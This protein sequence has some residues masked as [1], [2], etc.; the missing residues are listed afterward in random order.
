[1]EEQ[2]AS[3]RVGCDGIPAPDGDRRTPQWS[4]LTR[5]SHIFSSAVRESLEVGLLRDV[6]GDGL[7]LAQLHLLRFIVLTDDPPVGRVAEFLGVSAPA[8][9]KN[10]DKLES[11]GLVLRTRSRDDRRETLLTPTAEGERLVERFE[12]AERE[13]LA[14][15][16]ARFTADELAML[17]NLLERYS[18][19][20]IGSSAPPRGR[21]LRCSA[22]F[23]D[24]C[25][26]QFVHDGCPYRRS[27][28][29]RGSLRSEV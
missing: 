6:A 1:L 24:A 13:R 14:P 10:L 23:D 27:G 17:T 28:S 25:P 8:A 20:L 2:V 3:V 21:C 15:V 18:L 16:R 29:R 26:L 4:S 5:Y 7:T 12:E 19:A 22:Y 9:T 11:L